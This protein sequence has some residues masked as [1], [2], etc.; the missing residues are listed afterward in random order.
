M[1]ISTTHILSA[2]IL[3]PSAPRTYHPNLLRKAH[4][5]VLLPIISLSLERKLRILVLQTHI[6]NRGVPLL[7][8]G[9]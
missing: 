7:R 9:I 8:K 3:H 1:K 5:K 2:E 4:L 6:L